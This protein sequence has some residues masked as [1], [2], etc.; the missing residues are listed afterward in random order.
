MSSAMD[1]DEEEVEMASSSSGKGDKKRF[2][3]KKVTCQKCQVTLC[4]CLS[5]IT[6]F[7][8]FSVE[9]RG[10]MG[11][12][13]VLFALLMLHRPVLSDPWIC[14]QSN[15]INMI[16]LHSIFTA[17]VHCKMYGNWRYCYFQIL[18][19]TTALSAAIISWISALSVK[20]TK[21]LPPVKNAQSL[22][23]FVMWGQLYQYCSIIIIINCLKCF[24]FKLNLQFF[25]YI[26]TQLVWLY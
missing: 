11:L 16:Y 6:R 1:V 20:P 3:V 13:Y 15:T 9:C 8:S 5:I 2:E 7:S 10:V 21:L 4:H 24:K 19:L 25:F 26:E 23:V 12:G 22:G 18:L 14:H 17:Y